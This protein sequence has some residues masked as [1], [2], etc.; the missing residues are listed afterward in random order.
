LASDPGQAHVGFNPSANSCDACGQTFFDLNGLPCWFD[1]GLAQRHHWETLYTM[2]MAQGQINL[3]RS[4]ALKLG[5]LL[6]SSVARTQHTANLNKGIID[7]LD[8]LLSQLGLNKSL[9]AEFAHQDPSRFFAYFELLLRDWAWDGAVHQDNSENARELDRLGA[10]LE[11]AGSSDRR[12]ND[13]P[14]QSLEVRPPQLGETWIIGAGAGRLSYDF[15]LRFKPANTLALDISPLL[16]G[17][18]YRLVV[19]Q[20]PWQLP[21]LHSGPQQGYPLAKIWPMNTPKY[22]EGAI[23]N[24]FPLVGNAW[25]P[26]FKKHSFDAVV[27]PWFMD[28]NGRDVRE[29]IGLVQNYLKPGGLWLNTG[30]LL[31][32]A[33]IAESCRY[34]HEEILEL[35][36]LAGFTV[37]YHHTSQS[38]YLETPLS[39]QKRIEQIWTFAAFAPHQFPHRY[40]MCQPPAWIVL[41][42]LPIPAGIVLNTQ[43]NPVLEHLAAQVNGTNTINDIAKLMRPNLAEGKDALDIVRSAFL[44]YL[45]E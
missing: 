2:A 35:L 30:P 17:C 5:D 18:A 43:S 21:E 38:A 6:P 31:Y 41:P 1:I 33:D 15:H 32:G 4:Q 40:P 12:S 22:P 27:T 13:R 8:G 10:A 42:H 16:I 11:A 25:H 24:W 39:A 34:C 14:A 3:Q 7:S 29:L 28:V 45:L 23:D 9:N 44:E 37:V 19:Q 20:Q 36:A 26:P